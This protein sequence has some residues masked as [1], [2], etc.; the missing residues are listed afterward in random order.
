MV[1]TNYLWWWLGDGLLCLYPQIC[2]DH[3]WLQ[4]NKR[5]QKLNKHG[6]ETKEKILA[7]FQKQTSTRTSPKGDRDNILNPWWICGETTQKNSKDLTKGI[8]HWRYLEIISP[9]FSRIGVFSQVGSAGSLIFAEALRYLETRSLEKSAKD[10]KSNR[11]RMMQPVST[12][13]LRVN[14]CISAGFVSHSWFYYSGDV[15]VTGLGAKNAICFIHFALVR[16]GLMWHARKSTPTWSLRQ[17]LGRTWANI[18]Y[19][20]TRACSRGIFFTSNI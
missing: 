6:S 8:S 16:S 11:L 10:A 3:I 14:F 15:V 7:K 20:V 17:S 18:V 1:Y 19:R 2:M 13:L 5:T 9:W 4:V 12:I